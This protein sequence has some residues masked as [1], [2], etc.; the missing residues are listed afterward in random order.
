MAMTRRR[1]ETERLFHVGEHRRDRLFRDADSAVAL[2]VGM[3]AQWADARAGFAEIAAQQQ[4][5]RDLL[6][7]LRSLLVLGDAHAVADDR[8]VR[9]D[10]G[11][12]HPSQRAAVEAACGLDRLPMGLAQI[13]S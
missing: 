6:D 5:G 3:S 10:I 2:D 9:P 1:A 13:L 7:V 4:Q 8:S 12:S 11:V